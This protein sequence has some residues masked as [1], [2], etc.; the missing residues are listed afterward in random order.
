MLQ[1][2][3]KIE[4]L[5]GKSIA[6]ALDREVG[7]VLGPDAVSLAAAALKMPMN[8][9]QYLGKLRAPADTAK[10]LDL[11][12]SISGGVLV[13]KVEPT[14]PD[15]EAAAQV[16]SG[17]RRAVA[18]LEAAPNLRDLLQIAA[19]QVRLL[20]GFDRVMIYRSPA[21]RRYAVFDP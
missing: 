16:L 4:S 19:E 3:G 10:P 2:A 17:L 13:V 7:Q 21:A 14:G 5:T 11:T 9:P 18:Q 12:A 1:I 15:E 6:N 20:T 8:E